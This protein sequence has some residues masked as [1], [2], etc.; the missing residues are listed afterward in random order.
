MM[1]ERCLGPVV[2]LGTYASF[3]GDGGLVTSVID[4]AL[5]PGSTVFDSSPMY[6]TAERWLSA[7]LRDLG[8]ARRSRDSRHVSA[9]TC[10]RERGWRVG[11]AVRTRRM[12]SRRGTCRHRVMSDHECGMVPPR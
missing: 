1:G 5:A 6:G 11:A 2:G 3:E 4:A 9:V 8:F 12:A 10:C 7:A